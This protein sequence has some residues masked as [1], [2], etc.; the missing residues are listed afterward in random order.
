MSFRNAPQAVEHDVD[1]SALFSPEIREAIDAHIAK[2]PPEWKQSAVMPALSIVQDANGGWLTTELMDDVAAYLD[3]PAVSVYEV[4]TFY[5]MYDLTP[6]GRHKVCVCNSIS[7]MLNGS[8]ELIEHV[9][10][11]YGVKV[12]ET[13]SDGRFTLK[14]VE[15]LG[16]CR[17]APAVLLDKVYHEKLTPESLDKLIDGLE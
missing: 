7:C 16:A 11:K 6:Q 8:E 1:K 4:A 9:E 12:G 13:T 14:E 2:Y 10:H 3:M 5:G 17:D 15:C